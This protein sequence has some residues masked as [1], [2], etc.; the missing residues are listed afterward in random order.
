MTRPLDPSLL[1]TVN[2]LVDGLDHANVRYCLIGALVPELLLKTP[3]LRLPNDADAVV[4]VETFEEFERVKR[5]LERDRYG[6]SR[7]R[8]A[9][10]IGARRREG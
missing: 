5:V 10:R 1:E 3:P 9:F 6:F 7:T 2:A 4:Y 8:G